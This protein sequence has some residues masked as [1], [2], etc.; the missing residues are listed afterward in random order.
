MS[1][2]GRDSREG[3]DRIQHPHT[4]PDL[5]DLRYLRY[6]RNDERVERARKEPIHRREE[7]ERD[8]PGR[9]RPEDEHRE[10]GE[11][12]AGDEDVV[13]PEGVGEDG[14]EEAAEHAAGV[15]DGEDV[16]GGVGGDAVRG[17]VVDDVEEGDEEACSGGAS[18]RAGE[19]SVSVLGGR[20][21]FGVGVCAPR[22]M[23]TLPV[24]TRM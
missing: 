18:E 15:H 3:D 17:G 11:E 12:R 13:A 14:G 1:E 6:A 5:P 2:R 24:M 23:R 20:F 16:E 10:P 21:G 4:R 7:H 22:Q 8:E 19:V 9:E